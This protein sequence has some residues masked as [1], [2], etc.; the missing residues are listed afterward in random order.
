MNKLQYSILDLCY[1]HINY[2]SLQI[3]TLNTCAQVLS[4][5]GYLLDKTI[6][7]QHTNCIKLEI[8]ISLTIRNCFKILDG[9]IRLKVKLGLLL[10]IP[11]AVLAPCGWFHPEKTQ[12]QTIF[13]RVF[14]EKEK[15]WWKNFNLIM[16]CFKLS[17]RWVCKSAA[18]DCNLLT[19][20]FF[21]YIDKI[22]LEDRE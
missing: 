9:I 15:E 4:C 1:N 19:T 3:F 8:S 7:S 22:G 20:S 5:S 12:M 10:D 16:W 6:P 21:E 13:K 14:V 17:A 2:I 18:M 11:W